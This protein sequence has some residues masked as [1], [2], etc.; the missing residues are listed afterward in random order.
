MAFE[1]QTINHWNEIINHP[2]NAFVRFSHHLV[3]FY[4]Q[5]FKFFLH[6]QASRL[7]ERLAASDDFEQ[8]ARE[9]ALSA[10][11]AVAASTA[12]VRSVTGTANQTWNP[13][14]IKSFGNK[15]GNKQF[16][17]LLETSNYWTFYY[18]LFKW[19]INHWLV[20]P[21]KSQL[22]WISNG[23]QEVGLQMVR[24]SINHK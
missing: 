13:G 12:A 1:S 24:I 22:V 5:F 21:F 2:N 6:F 14:K 18:S 4:E 20:Q 9:A 23:Q 8:A 10:A 15:G 7:P 3:I 19:R 11:Q 17:K 16:T